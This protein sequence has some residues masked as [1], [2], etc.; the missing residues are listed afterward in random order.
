FSGSLENPVY[1]QIGGPDSTHYLIEAGDCRGTMRNR[2]KHDPR[3]MSASHRSRYLERRS[4]GNF[5]GK[6]TFTLGGVNWRLEGVQRNPEDGHWRIRA[7]VCDS[8]P[9]ARPRIGGPATEGRETTAACSCGCD[10][11]CYSCGSGYRCGTDY[12]DACLNR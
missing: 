2:G 3:R 11:Y 7:R 9:D 5:A 4:G 8:N 6:Q 10:E 12:A 1:Q